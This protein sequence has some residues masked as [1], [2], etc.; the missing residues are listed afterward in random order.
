MIKAII[1]IFEN[2]SVFR[3]ILLLN[4]VIILNKKIGTNA[5][6]PIYFQ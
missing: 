5:L 3:S 6:I 4:I 1:M 2:C